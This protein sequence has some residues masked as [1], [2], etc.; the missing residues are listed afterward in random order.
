M[1]LLSTPSSRTGIRE[2][3]TSKAGAA[4]QQAR[5]RSGLI[6]P[7]F[8]MAALLIAGL[9]PFLGT[10]LYWVGLLTQFLSFAVL[11]ISV[12]LL[13]GFGGLLPFG[14][15]AVF[16]VGAYSAALSL[17]HWGAVAGAWLGLVLA[18]MVPAAFGAVLA[19]FLFS[20]R[21]QIVGFGFGIVTLALGLALQLIV[22]NWSSFTGGSNGLFG[23]DPPSPIPGM[24]LEPGLTAYYAVLIGVVA[25]YLVSRF[26]VRS[27]FG[28]V[29]LATA[30]DEQRTGALGHPVGMIRAC[31]VVCSF[32][33]AGFAGALYV[34]SGFATP[35]LLGLGTSTAALVWVAIGGRGTLL[36]AALGAV[37]LSV[38]Q[39]FLTGNF[40]LLSNL[41][42]GLL[43]ILVVLAWPTGFLG[44]LRAGLGWLR[45]RLWTREAK[46]LVRG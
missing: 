9:L 34:P 22:T 24:P 29:L 26:L 37:G 18:I 1:N 25:A 38:L 41:V 28:L 46:G 17:H 6:S 20:G 23:Y 21:V 30:E 12:D 44:A 4:P 40:L 11:A 42:L 2:G 16:G 35:D 36:G 45:S 33:L 31:T 32:G 43:L 27:R 7:V 5:I 8:E 10:D 3:Q 14:Q 13:W 15:A 39:E 19:W